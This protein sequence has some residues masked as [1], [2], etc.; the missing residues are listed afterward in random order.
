[1][2]WLEQPGGWGVVATTFSLGLSTA[3]AFGFRF[4]AF[5]VSGTAGDTAGSGFVMEPSCP[6]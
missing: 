5:D 3:H 2:P 1:M 6:L 4:I